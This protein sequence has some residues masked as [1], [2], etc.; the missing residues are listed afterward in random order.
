MR[1]IRPEEFPTPWLKLLP[2]QTRPPGNPGT[3]IKYQYKDIVT[4]FDIETTRLAD[5]DQ[6]VMYIWQWCFGDRFVVI[7]RTWDEFLDFM[8]VIQSAL[9]DGERLYCAVHNLS[10]E[11]HFLRGIHEFAAKDVFAIKSRKV[12]SALWGQVEFRCSY[13]HSNMSLGEFCDKMHVQ[14]RKLSG[15]EY[16]YNK[17]RYPW[18]PMSERELQY[19]IN[20]VVGLVEALT[21]EMQHDGDNLYTLPPT[22]TG[23]VRRDAKAAM[24]EVSWYYVHNQ[25]PTLPIFTMLREAFRGGDV[26][27]NRFFSGQIVDNVHSADRSSSYPD[28]VCN[29]LF[30]VSEFFVE[31]A[32]LEKSDV[33]K[34][35]ETRGRAVIMR[36]AIS[37]LK[38]L[39]A[40]YP[41]PYLSRDKSR[42]MIGGE[43]D[44]GRVLKAEYLETTLT[45]V[46]FRIILKEYYWDDIVFLDVAHARYGKLPQSLIN[47]AIEYYKAK[48]SLKGVPEQDV[49][50]TKSKNKLNSIYGMMAQN[51]CRRKLVYTQNG[52][53]DEW[54]LIDYYP[55]DHTKS[56]QEIL[57]EANRKAFLCYQWGCWVTAWARYRLREGIWTVLDQDSEWLY[58]DTDSVKYLGEV[59]WTA[60]NAE[61]IKASTASG[62]WADDP[63][64][65][66]HYMGV[67]EQEEDMLQFRTWGAKKYVYTIPAGKKWKKRHPESDVEIVC[68]TAGVAK[69]L[70]ADELYAAGGIK[71]YKPGFVFHA[72]GGLEAVYNDE[73]DELVEIDGHELHIT[74]NVTLRESTYELG[75]S[76]D[77]ERLLRR[78]Q[79][80]IDN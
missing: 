34:L 78:Y 50:Y 47:C 48:T 19:C 4:A 65:Q 49:Y 5:I 55:E 39:D 18:T 15:D 7:G 8:E 16:D 63:S 44:N 68:T 13:I 57:D 26:H 60:Y 27:A 53:I 14:H 31:P 64:G 59:D 69:T 24:R 2:C 12:L 61:R 66:R 80:S 45:D 32:R 77:Y 11:F 67:Y 41:A 10:Y 76:G 54:G 17:T 37:G 23:Y 52:V 38:L 42:N 3:R 73:V 35:I 46:D 20:D 40:N 58:A 9:Q 62:A 72:A 74:P 21:A 79:L 6:T 75:L 29:D 25:L 1:I 36:V 51:P 56:N 71:A 33:L 43:Y 22:S 30:P 28:I 70:G